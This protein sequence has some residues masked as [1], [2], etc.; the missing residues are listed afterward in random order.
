VPKPQSEPQPDPDAGHLPY[1][2]AV[3]Y[4]DSD[5]ELAT[6]FYPATL[7]LPTMGKFIRS[8]IEACGVMDEKGLIFIPWNRIVK[9]R[10][11]DAQNP[12]RR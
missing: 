11:L 5:N 10:K 12:V 2:W 6:I 1:T 9:I 7:D 8:L 4:K 3:D